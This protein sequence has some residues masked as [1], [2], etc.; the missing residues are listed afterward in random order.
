MIKFKEVTNFQ[1]WS[2]GYWHGVGITALAFVVAF[3]LIGM[4]K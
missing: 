4:M 2:N 1:D 3:L